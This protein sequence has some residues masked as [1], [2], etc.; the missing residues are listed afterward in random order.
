M[1]GNMQSI[2]GYFDGNTCIPL[3][4]DIFTLNQKVIIT[5]LDSSEENILSDKS[6]FFGAINLS[7]EPL[8]IQKEMRDEW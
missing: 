7:K 4:K 3:N 1:G 5:A 6:E 2:Y 8:D